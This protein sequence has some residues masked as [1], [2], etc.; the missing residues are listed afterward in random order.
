MRSIKVKPK[1]ASGLL[2]KITRS[3]AFVVRSLAADLHQESA[4]A[5]AER[6]S[7]P[8]HDSETGLYYNWNRYYDPRIG[9]YIS[10]DPVG[11]LGGVNTY[12][13]AYSNPLRFTDPTGLRGPGAAP[14]VGVAPGGGA[15]IGVPGSNESVEAVLNGALGPKMGSDPDMRNVIQFPG[16]RPAN[17]NENQCSVNDPPDDP[18]PAAQFRLENNRKFGEQLLTSLGGTGVA[19]NQYNAFARSFN[20]TVKGHNRACPKNKVAELPEIN[21]PTGAV[22]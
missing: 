5:N 3:R 9:R 17:K 18:C 16:S 7:A 12:V 13:Y 4:F 22:Q 1:L 6:A 15:I 8:L 20:R 19:V 2:E 14:G 21:G 11:L 10:S